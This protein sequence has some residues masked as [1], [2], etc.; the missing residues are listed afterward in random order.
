MYARKLC[1]EFGIEHLRLDN[2]RKI[3]NLLSDFLSPEPGPKVLEVEGDTGTNKVVFE[4]LKS[5]IKQS[6]EL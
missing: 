1:E 2:A 6:Y 5:Q 4:R 3:K